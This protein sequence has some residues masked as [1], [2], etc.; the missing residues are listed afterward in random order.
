[1]CLFFVAIK[2]VQWRS[3]DFLKT[4]WEIIL[5]KKKSEAIIWGWVHYTVWGSKG[6][7]ISWPSFRG[8]NNID[9]IRNDSQGAFLKIL[10]HPGISQGSPHGSLVPP[11]FC[12]ATA[13]VLEILNSGKDAGEGIEKLC[14]HCCQ[15]HF[16]GIPL[17]ALSAPF[18]SPSPWSHPDTCWRTS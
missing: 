8:I 4:Q 1:M 10:F 11:H 9:Q 14:F 16:V 2:L 18:P 17:D 7:C 13:M 12:S 6:S 15:Q 3:K 5:L